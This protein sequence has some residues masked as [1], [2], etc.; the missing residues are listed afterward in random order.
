MTSGKR[1]KKERKRFQ[2]MGNKI[3]DKT[4]CFAGFTFS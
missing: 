2:N 4:V 3:F 1:V